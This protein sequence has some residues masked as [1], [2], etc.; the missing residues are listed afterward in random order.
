MG[1][2][3]VK[4]G[5]ASARSTLL[6]I[7]VILAVLVWALRDVAVLIG[8]SVLLAYAL[9]PT[10]NVL[11]RLRLGRA[12]HLPRGIVAGGVML[13]LVGLVAWLLALAVPQIAAEATRLASAAP[14]TL[15]RLIDSLDRYASTHGLDPWL[16]PAIKNARSDVPGL[17]QSLG[18]TLALWAGR[19]FEGMGQLLGLA[20]MPLLAFYLLAESAAVQTSALRFMPE[21]MHA[22][23]ARLGAAVDRA[24]RSYVRGQA[25]VSLVMGAAVGIALALLHYPA[26][27]L[28]GL[29]AGTAELIPYLGF[30]VAAVTITLA[31]LSVTPI[32]ALLGVATYTALNWAIGAFVTPRVMGRFLKMHP[33]VV[34][35]SVL[36]GA[37]LLGP[38]GALLALPGAAMLQ[39]LVGELAGPGGNPRPRSP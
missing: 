32:H 35:V 4:A 7:A 37:Q 23:I 21:E 14:E 28:L 29:L 16:A 18:A 19:S 3:P 34:T 25:I 30:M 1:S 5:L 27:L 13:T 24:L 20:L 9:L 8:Y 31:G 38:T 10:V 15:T 26:A 2:A 11:E 17:L 12:R 36:A 22:E 6:W 33:F 39:A